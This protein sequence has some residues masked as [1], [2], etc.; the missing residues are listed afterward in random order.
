MI[1]MQDGV[2]A[3]SSRMSAASR[4]PAA[5]TTRI[6]GVPSESRSWRCSLRPAKS[7]HQFPASGC[8]SGSIAPRATRSSSRST[9]PSPTPP[10]RSAT[11]TEAVAVTASRRTSISTRPRRSL[12]DARSGG[13]EGHHHGAR[14][15]W[16]RDQH[17]DSAAAE[18]PPRL[19]GR[20]RQ[21]LVSG[22]WLSA[23]AS[24]QATTPSLSRAGS[25]AGALTT[26]PPSPR[27]AP[28]RRG[29]GASPRSSR[30]V[31]SARGRGAATCC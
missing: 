22:A 1:N 13:T 21:R 26:A 10:T 18:A 8:S 15:Q 12:A 9:T 11:T 4:A 24:S 19:H 5:E 2:V 7:A 31:P 16:R 14:R 23:R 25:L 30:C 6:C 29:G 27:R 3:R 17:L 20:P 28:P